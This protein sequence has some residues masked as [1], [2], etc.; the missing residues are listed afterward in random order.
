MNRFTDINDA[1]MTSLC[2]LAILALA[3]YALM[4]LFGDG[5][6]E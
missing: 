3:L 5:E 4:K 6:D 2:L 1:A